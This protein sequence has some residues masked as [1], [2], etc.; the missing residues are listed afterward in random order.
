MGVKFSN[1]AEGTLSAG[2]NA[3]VTTLTLNAG[4][5]AYFPIVSAGASDYFWATLTNVAGQR[6]IIKVTQHSAGDVF[7]TIERAADSIQ[8]EAVPT[9]YSFSTNDTCQLRLN[10]EALLGFSQ[11]TTE[12][13]YIIDIPNSGPRVKNNAGTMEIR[14]NAD[15]DYADLHAEGL[16]LEAALAIGG[17]I[18]GATTINASGAATVASLVLSG[19]IT[20]AT[21][22]NASGAITGLSLA[23]GGAITGATSIACSSVTASGTIT[24]E[25]LTSTDDITA[26]GTV[27]AEHLYSTDDAV[28]NDDLLV[29]GAAQ[30]VGTSTLGT[31]NAS[32]AI[33]ARDHGTAATDEVVNVCYGTGSPPAA[34]STTIGALFIK[35]VA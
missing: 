35:Y 13:S 18:T 4:E 15:G 27:Q 1:N 25:Q 6:E 29:S 2:I 12:T 17:A 31:V 5:G 24:A 7:Q 10:K 16:T 32:G 33:T 22:I 3:V 26:V 30:V 34:S 11:G 14:N 9:A 8:E 23:L 20:G 19:S 21:T 28:I